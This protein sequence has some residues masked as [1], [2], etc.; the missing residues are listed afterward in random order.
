MLA[1]PI[2]KKRMNVRQ[3]RFT[4]SWL[5][6]LILFYL[7]RREDSEEYLFGVEENHIWTLENL[8]LFLH[9]KKILQISYVSLFCR[10]LCPFFGYF[11]I[12]L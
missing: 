2:T 8:I 12:N 9:F 3:D 5:E 7:R 4:T 10:R 11:A 1:G 6:S